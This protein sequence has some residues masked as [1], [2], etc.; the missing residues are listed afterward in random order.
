MSVQFPC[1]P[2]EAERL[3]VL[4]DL[5]IL[6][7]QPEESFDR[8][9]RLVHLIFDVPI[10]LVSLMDADRQWFKATVGLDDQGTDRGDAFCRFTVAEGRALIVQDASQDERFRDHPSV[11]GLPSIRFYA[12]FPLKVDGD[13]CAGTLC[14]IG[15]KPRKLDERESQIL[16]DLAALAENELE[17]RRTAD[18]DTL[19]ETLTRRAFKRKALEL[20]NDRRSNNLPISAIVFDLD[21]FKAVN[22][23]FGHAGG[24]IVLSTIARVCKAELRASDVFGRLGGE[25]FGVLLPQTDEAGA[26]VVAE[27]LRKVI[28]SKVIRLSG[29]GH[30]VTASFGTAT[31]SVFFPT[32]EALLESADKALYAEKKERTKPDSCLPYMSYHPPSGLKALAMATRGSAMGR[33]SAIAFRS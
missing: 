25:E 24:D 14:A 21:H 23:T 27:K 32:I 12:G 31:A 6:D 7:T 1:L 26:R 8:I 4:K 11:A 10:A 33:R 15:M 29:Q 16:A 17:L 13:K 3:R 22:D 19:T 30:Q 2:N 5:Q 28:E 20:A 18:V 9:A